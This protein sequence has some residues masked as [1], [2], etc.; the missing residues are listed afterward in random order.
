MLCVEKIILVDIFDRQIGT[1]EKTEAHRLPR[2]HRAF[3]VF[4]HHEGKMLIQRRAAHKYHSGGLWANACC[5][6]PKDGER[7]ED[8]VLR[9]MEQELG[10]SVNAEEMFSF[11]Y[12]NKFRD[13]MFEYE[14]DHVFV[15]DYSGKLTP[16]GDE[17]DAVEWVEFAEVARR[18]RDAPT[19]FAPWFPIAAP[20]VLKNLLTP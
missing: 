5:S 9:R 6:H 1:A 2:L 13:D 3:S 20:L 18:L 8:A 4:V 12:L 15:A 16:N 7:T 10:V 19:I 11:V 14:Y 17:I